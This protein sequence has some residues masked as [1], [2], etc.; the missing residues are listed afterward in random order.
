[1][2][3][4][5]RPL[6]R[7]LLGK[8]LLKVDLNVLL[9]LLELYHVDVKEGSDVAD[10]E[11]DLLL[12]EVNRLVIAAQLDDP[13]VSQGVVVLRNEDVGSSQLVELADTLTIVADDEGSDLVR[14]RD[15]SVRA[16]ERVNLQLLLELPLLLGLL[17][18]G[19]TTH[20]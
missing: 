20:H 19:P 4:A 5:S 14:D 3:A 10:D 7:C 12:A 1:M 18:E 17:L 16:W 9:I 11:L 2:L 6:E 8:Q 15:E 13:L